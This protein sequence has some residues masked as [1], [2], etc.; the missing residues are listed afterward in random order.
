MNNTLGNKTKENILKTALQLWPDVTPS[1][2]ARKLNITH[3][4]VLYH[5]KDLK[6]STAEYALKT[7]CKRVLIQMWATDHPLL[8]GKDFKTI[9]SQDGL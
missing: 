4:A 9:L 3:A 6:Q 2:V 8:K 7:N 1:N 5:F